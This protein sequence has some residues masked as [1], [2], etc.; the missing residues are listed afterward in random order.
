MKVSWEYYSH[1]LW[2]TIQMFQTTNQKIIIMLVLMFVGIFEGK[3]QLQVNLSDLT[4]AISQRTRGFIIIVI[5]PFA[6]STMP[7]G[8]LT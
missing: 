3:L 6:T 2:K 1:I 4:G 7:S 8:Q 5:P